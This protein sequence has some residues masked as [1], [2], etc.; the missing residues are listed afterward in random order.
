M[1]NCLLVVD[2]DLA[3]ANEI[4]SYFRQQRWTTHACGSAEEA[5][6]RFTGLRP[7]LVLAEH[8][9]PQTTGSELAGRIAKA[10]QNIKLVVMSADGSAS[11]ALL[12]MKAGACHYLA[13][14]VALADMQVVF[15]RVLAERSPP[16]P[17][18]FTAGIEAILGKSP[19]IQHLKES[20][21]Q[22]HEAGKRMS[23]DGF[24]AVLVRGETGTGKEL[25][26]RALHANVPGRSGQLVEINCASIPSQ[27]LE[28]ELFGFRKGAFTGAQ[29]DKPGLI[30][31]ADGGT[32]FLDEIGEIDP[33][34]QAKLLKL[35][36]D[37]AYR[38]L[39]SVQVKQANVRIVSATNRDLEDMVR[40]GLFRIDLYFRL[41]V[42]SLTVPP[43]RLRG[44]DILMLARHFLALHARRYCSPA[45]AFDAEAEQALQQ[46]DWP[47]NVRELRNLLEEVVIRAPGEIITARQLK[48]PA[49]RLPTRLRAAQ[50]AAPAAPNQSGLDVSFPANRQ[51]ILDTLESTGGNVSE[52][53]RLLGMTRDK[54][55][56]RIEKMN[57]AATLNLRSA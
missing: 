33:N 49:P 30:E 38:P 1:T 57:L 27:L 52:S 16:K 12:A 20:I 24:P 2:Q 5:L 9:L 44:A 39:G 50:E 29:N 37:K 10:N 36:E 32:L 31:A 15:N 51:L 34:I 53:A 40:A 54:M 42:I 19:P 45:A 17:P 3:L 8:R 43:L 6:L 41:R 11:T 21:R 25:V 35:L 56:Q 48:L 22:L 18:H 26:A 13:K 4:C 14:P 23:D 46:H 28:A 55:R 47:G 7:D